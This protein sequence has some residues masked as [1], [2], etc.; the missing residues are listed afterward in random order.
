MDRINHPMR[1]WKLLLWVL[2]HL[3]MSQKTGAQEGLTLPDLCEKVSSL[4]IIGNFV[5]VL[6]PVLPA[7][8]LRCGV[9]GPV[10]AGSLG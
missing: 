4:K 1:P 2:G 6:D 7:E 5:P 10:R 8:H 9:P 3:S